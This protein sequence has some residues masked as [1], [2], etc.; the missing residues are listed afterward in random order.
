MIRFIV[1]PAAKS[2]HARDCMEKMIQALDRAHVPYSV[3]ETERPRH[4]P[5]LAKELALMPETEV[6]GVV[7]GDGTLN[8]LISGETHLYPPIL[9]VPYGSGNDFARGI[10]L[11][12]NAG[13][14]PDYAVDYSTL[15]AEKVDIGC[16]ETER[17]GRH[18]FIV[19]GGIG[20]DAAVCADMIKGKWKKRLNRIRLGFLTYLI[21]GLKNL[22]FCPLSNG[23][24]I[25]ND[26]EKTFSL[27]KIAFMSAHNLP[28]EGGG[29]YFAP[30]AV[31]QDGQ[32]DVCV[33]TARNHLRFILCLLGTVLG[34]KHIKM[35]GVHYF[36]CRKAELNLD[37]PLY[38][39][40]DGELGEKIDHI[41][42]RTDEA[43]LKVLQ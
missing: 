1:N 40:T 11:K 26:G 9:Y 8:E 18:R 5:H 43:T 20:F 23:K 27:K 17:D 2:W 24:L 34:G 4:M 31:P 33:V 10:G 41:T 14:A 25:I 37:K 42:F 7:G 22:L 36:R 12:V 6:I 21:Y 39:H 15:A 13:S 35:K 3:H 16:V 28:Y 30:K 32:L 29:F 38:Y 19:S